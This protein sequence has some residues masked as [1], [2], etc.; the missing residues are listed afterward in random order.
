MSS[1]WQPGRRGRRM[2]GLGSA[3]DSQCHPSHGGCRNPSSVARAHDRPCVGLVHPVAGYRMFRLAHHH[4]GADQIGN[5]PALRR[6]NGHHPLRRPYG[7]LFS[8]VL[9]CL[10]IWFV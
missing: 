10:L 4:N 2:A 5:H 8:G 7:A 6:A 1:I 9:D 3:F